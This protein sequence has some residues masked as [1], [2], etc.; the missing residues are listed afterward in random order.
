MFEQAALAHQ[1]RSWTL[2]LSLFMQTAGAGAVVLLS[3]L[4][5]EKLPDVS[6]PIALP[7]VP[8]APQAVEVVMTSI[9]REARSTARSVFVAPSRIPQRVAMIV[10]QITGVEA[11]EKV[12]GGLEG[13]GLPGGVYEGTQVWHV[14]GP[15]PPTPPKPVE[16]P[17]QAQE[18]ARPVRVGGNVLEARIVKRVVPQYPVMARNMRISGTVRLE[19]II[20]RDGTVREL[21]VL[22]GHPML[23]KAAL[24]AVKQWI[25]QPTLLNGEPVEVNAPIE[26]HFTLSQ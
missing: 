11:G 3:I 19:G 15:P 7:P 1:K 8:R 12:A 2:L 10:D 16:R 17:L 22:S 13:T 9:V 20:A 4:S 26:V 23:V 14:P 24:D 5:I 25:Y 18:S 6:L 21:K